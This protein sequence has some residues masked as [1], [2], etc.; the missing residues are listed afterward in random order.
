[1]C[2]CAN[3]N[4]LKVAS[5]IEKLLDQIAQISP[6]TKILLVSPITLGENVWKEEY[7]PEFSRESVQVS[8]ELAAEYTKLAAQKNIAFLDAASV[9]VCSQADQEHMDAKGHRKL[10]DAVYDE[11][12]GWF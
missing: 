2:C 8:R 10:A 7:D 4:I 6:K 5:G 9:V 11:V 12:E 1:M 3:S